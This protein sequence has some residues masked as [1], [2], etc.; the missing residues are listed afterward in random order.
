[1][2]VEV[3]EAK[4]IEVSPRTIIEG[5]LGVNGR[6]QLD[7]LYDVGLELG[8]PEQRV[9]LAIRRMEAAGSLRQLGRGRAGQLERTGPAIAEAAAEERLVDFAFTQDAG[10]APWDGRWR[11]LAFSIPEAERA[12]RD[13]VRGA[14]TLLGAVALAPGMYLSSHELGPEVGRLLALKGFESRLIEAATTELHVPG[15]A[16]D[17]AIAERYWPAEP[18]LAAYAPLGRELVRAERTRPDGRVAIAA[19]ALQLSEALDQALRADPLVPRELR[20]RDWHPETVRRRFLR[21]WEDLRALAPE[22]PMFED[23]PLAT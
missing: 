7:F 20:A 16:D 4:T 13:A 19:Q 1:M 2:T 21:V 15:C 12:E 17:V 23:A 5:C 18:T 6:A 3:V 10:G 22:L 8:V 11:I 14:L 9:R